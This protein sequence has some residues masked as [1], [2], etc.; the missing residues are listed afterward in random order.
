L[1]PP[2]PEGNKTLGLCKNCQTVVFPHKILDRP[3]EGGKLPPEEECPVCGANELRFIDAREPKGFFTDLKPEDFDGKFEWS[4]RSSR[5]SLS[6]TAEVPT[7]LPINDTNASVSSFNENIISVNDNG[8]QGG[9]DFFSRVKIYGDEKNGAYA[10]A[11]D[12]DYVNSFGTSYRIALLSQRKTDILLIN[13]NQWQEGVFA[14]PTTVEGKAAWYS[15]AFWLRIASS[16]LLDIDFQE[17]QAGMRSVKFNDLVTGQV[18][19]CDALENGAG[20]CSYLAQSE[21]FHSLLRQGDYK[22]PNSIARRWLK[23][24]HQKDCDT[25]CNLC[26]RDYRNLPYH[27][28]LD[29][30]LALDMARLLAYHDSPI[31]LRTPWGDFPNPW[32]R[33]I[34]GENAPIPNTLKLLGYGEPL[35]FASLIGFKHQGRN[36]KDILIL[37]HP[38]WNDHHPEWI[39]ASLIA[40]SQYSG[41]NI[42]AG[43]P[44]ILL[45]R[46]AEYV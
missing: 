5:P 31:D 4:P 20:Y 45:R 29:W 38:L 12:N 35:Q 33:L 15:L 14:N 36:R 16:V 44:F 42:I 21:Q 9:F 39:K 25:S 41:S 37:R 8:G 10:V 34:E 18:F 24:D 19:L 46:P 28:I 27:G 40:L 11:T 17:L 30:R 6:V 26:L 7:P 43:N 23:E 13:F 32:Q 22:H 3:P 2:L 1:S